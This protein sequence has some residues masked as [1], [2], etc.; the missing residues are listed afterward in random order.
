[1]GIPQSPD[2]HSQDSC[3]PSIC[4]AVPFVMF[5]HYCS[6]KTQ[7]SPLYT[8]N[9]GEKSMNWKEQLQKN[10]PKRKHAHAAADARPVRALSEISPHA[11]PEEVIRI[12]VEVLRIVERET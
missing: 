9:K 10:K 12:E 5:F 8:S 1:D 4:G 2:G 11:T 6:K 3:C 7:C